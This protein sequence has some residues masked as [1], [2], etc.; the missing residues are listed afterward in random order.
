MKRPLLV[1]VCFSLVSIPPVE[2]PAK[3]VLVIAPKAKGRRGKRAA[4]AAHKAVLL[5]LREVK[6]IEVTSVEGRKARAMRRC[7]RR[8][9][10][11]QKVGKKLQAE[12]VLVSAVRERRRRLAV[13]VALLDAST[14]EEVGRDRFKGRRSRAALRRVGQ[15]AA[16]LVKGALIK[17][18]A[19]A[20]EPV[21]GPTQPVAQASDNED[22]R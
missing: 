2:A 8:N 14:E 9:G 5:H 19:A 20:P 17:A 15:L 16:R 3:G 10:C 22:P 13:S 21:P 4:K 18:K 11:V 6:G 1:V 7:L 12:L